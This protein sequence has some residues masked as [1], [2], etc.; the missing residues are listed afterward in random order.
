MN[1]AASNFPIQSPQ[2]ERFGFALFLAAAV[3]ALVILGVVFD[4]TDVRQTP[5]TLEVTLAQH[6][7]V[8][9]PKDAD[10]LAQYNQQASGSSALPRELSS[11]RIPELADTHI[12]NVSPLPQQQAARPAAQQ[13]QLITTSGASTW[14]AP[15]Q[16]A[17]DK[18][19]EQKPGD[20]PTELPPSKPE[21]T[22]LQARL[23]KIR[24]TLAQRPRVR[25]LTSVATRNSA[26]AAY[27]HAW[28]QR[29]ELVGNENF[30][31][32]ALQR[33]LTGSL[34]LMVRLLPS[35][36]VEDVVVL[37]SSGKDILDDAARQ[38]VHL[39]APFAPFPEEI[40]QQTD[41]LEI[42]RTWHFEMAKLS[43]TSNPE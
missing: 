11:D 16:P 36:A 14:T 4:A 15:E 18:H 27:L 8:D 19:A 9:E 31:P 43:T 13:R 20:A 17:K 40:R 2:A 34:R 7:S 5:P 35:G 1:S 6:R 38:I 33:K 23:D 32:E 26:D 22:S 37:S 39:A 24:Q 21:I 25:R 41:R 12:R 3:H 10:Y 28:R 42:I 29:V 30:P